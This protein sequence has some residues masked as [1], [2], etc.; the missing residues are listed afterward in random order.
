MAMGNGS[1]TLPGSSL[2]LEPLG[3]RGQAIYWGEHQ[4]QS[5]ESLR[6]DGGVARESCTPASGSA[7]LVSPRLASAPEECATHKAGM[8]ALFAALSLSRSGDGLPPGKRL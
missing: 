4:V 7:S 5:R 8:S 6:E 2:V 3:M 1:G